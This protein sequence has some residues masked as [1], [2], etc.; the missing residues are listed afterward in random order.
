[1][2]RIIAAVPCT[3]LFLFLVKNLLK[4]S[5]AEKSYD[6][7]IFPDEHPRLFDFIERLCEE[8]GAPRTPGSANDE[9]GRQRVELQERSR[10]RGDSMIKP[11]ITIDPDKKLMIGSCRC[12]WQHEVLLSCGGSEAALEIDFAFWR[13]R[14]GGCPLTAGRLQLIQRLRGK[15]PLAT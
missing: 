15:P 5:P 11:K 6:I 1:V 2:V 8:T 13:H 3:L 14:S 12:G 9:Y 4:W 10:M 7:E